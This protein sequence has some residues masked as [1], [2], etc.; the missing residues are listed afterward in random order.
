MLL[1]R[2]FIDGGFVYV[3]DVMYEI[4]PRSLPAEGILEIIQLT[5]PRVNT[6]IES[7]STTL[8]LILD[9]LPKGWLDIIFA[10]D[11]VVNDHDDD[12]PNIFLNIDDKTCVASSLTTKGATHLLRDCNMNPPKGEVFWSTRFTD[13]NFSKRWLNIYKGIN[14]NFEADLNF[15]ILHNILFTNDKLHKFGLIESPLCTL[16]GTETESLFHLCIACPVVNGLWNKIIQKLSK[17]LGD[18]NLNTWVL[19]TLF[20]TNLTYSNKKRLLLDFVLT[21]Y[22]SVIYNARLSVLN[23]NLVLSIDNYFYNSLRKKI[24]L[25]YHCFKLKGNISKFWSIFLNA[26]VIEFDHESE[27]KFRFIFDTG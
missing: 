27:T 21:I 7:V 16:C 12:I 10:S 20:G 9:S 11:K 5:N 3:S 22:K 6:D 1:N 23:D 2:D 18:D 25:V 17:H 13:L 24:E 15:K 19:I 26:E 8:Q 4:L 14:T